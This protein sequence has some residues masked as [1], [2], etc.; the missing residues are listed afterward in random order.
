VSVH[1]VLL[2]DSIFDNAAYV[3][4][5]CDVSTHL[6]AVV[7]DSA[8]VTML[9]V[10]GAVIDDVHMQL[11]SVPR[12]ASRL[13]LSVGGNDALR[14]AHL[15]DDATHSGPRLLKEFAAGVSGFDARY[16]RLLGALASLGL[17]AFACTIYEGNLPAD[18]A[19]L[20]RQEL[21]NS[22]QPLS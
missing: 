17:P 3:P 1:V 20:R 15:L 5:G 21:T 16:R 14:Y 22:G 11:R 13:V 8:S 6:R 9:A 10:D 7:R 2:G 19:H 4:R 12:D 18:I